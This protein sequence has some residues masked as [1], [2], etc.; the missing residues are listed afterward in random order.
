AVCSPVIQEVLQGIR[1]EEIAA[2]IKSSLLSFKLAG[3][4]INVD[5]YIEASNIY[6]SARRRGITIRSSIDCLIAAI[7]LR[8]KLPVWHQDRD[9]VEIAKFTELKNYVHR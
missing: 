1:D 5:H 4:D 9:F 6:R 7:A 2:K 3:A 8:E